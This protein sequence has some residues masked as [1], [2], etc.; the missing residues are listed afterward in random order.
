MIRFD[1]VNQPVFNGVELKK[2]ISASTTEPPFTSSEI[3]ELPSIQHPT[4]VNIP[5]G[6]TKMGIEKLDNGQ[7]IHN[8]KLANG[9]RVSILPMDTN[10][11]VI[12][13]FVNTGAIN[14]IDSQRGISHFLEHMAFNGT[15][16][17][18]GYKKLATGDVFKLVSNIGGYTNAATN[19]ALTDYFIQAPIFFDSDLY[20]ARIRF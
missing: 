3:K 7:E 16:G 6:Y 20:N 5:C 1:K 15:N 9:L 8:Y 18:N 10:T 2:N 13:S 17:S 19:F 14:E 4:T 11:T 12:R